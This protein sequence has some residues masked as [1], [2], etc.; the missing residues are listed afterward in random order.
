LYLPFSA[1]FWTKQNSVW[2]KIYQKMV[3]VIWFR[4]EIAMLIKGACD[5]ASY[6]IACLLWSVLLF[7]SFDT[8][9]LILLFIFC[10]RD[11]YA[12]ILVR[13]L[14]DLNCWWWI[15]VFFPREITRNNPSIFSLNSFCTSLGKLV[16]YFL[17]NWMG[18]DC[19]DSFPFDFEPNGFPFHSKSKGK[20]SPRSYPIQFETKWNTSFQSIQLSDVQLFKRLASLG[21]MGL[22][23]RTSLKALDPSTMVSRGLRGA[24]NGAFLESPR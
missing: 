23:L 2:F 7:Y 3:N 11:C 17:S 16:F 18:C 6:L 22:Q 14:L 9:K 10:I 4:L 8:I 20:L 5:D 12:Y 1:R 19:G 24:L 13:L 21:I 15:L